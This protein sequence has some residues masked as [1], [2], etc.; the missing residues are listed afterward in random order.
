MSREEKKEQFK[1]EKKRRAPWLILVVVLIMTGGVS[2]WALLTGGAQSESMFK[3]NNGAVQ[4]PQSDFADGT[5]KFYKVKGSR[6]EIAFFLVKSSDGVLRAAFDTCDVCYK[7]KK[8]YRQEGNNMICN[9]CG[10]KFRSD[11]I[12]VVKGGCNPAPLQRELV[13]DKV[14]IQLAALEQGSWYFNGHPQ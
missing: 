1:Q 3:V 13:G 10:Q 7:E 4:I 6:G 8:G 14:V 5:A 2:A 12:N 9:N 11:L